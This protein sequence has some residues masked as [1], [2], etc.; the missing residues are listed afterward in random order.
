MRLVKL[1]FPGAHAA[2]QNLFNLGRH[3]VRSEQGGCLRL[4]AKVIWSDEA[5]LSLPEMVFLIYNKINKNN[6]LK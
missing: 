2:V 6:I 3:L 5:D 4:G 1:W